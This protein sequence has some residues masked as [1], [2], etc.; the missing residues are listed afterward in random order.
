VSPGLSV[1]VPH[2]HDL[3]SLDRCLDCLSRQTY[4]A[5]QF[6]IIVADN[7][8]PEGL[9]EVARLVG[10]R[11][12]L[13]RVTEPGA[14]PARN[15]GVAL[16]RGAILAF[17]DCDCQPE[18]EWLAAG[19]RALGSC[20]I[21][22]G[23]MA[24][25]V[26]DPAHM[27]P[28]EAFERVFAFDNRSYVMRKGFTVTANLFCPRAIF[29]RVGGFL[30]ARVSEDIEWCHR[31]RGAGFRL[32]YAPEAV[33]GHPARRSWPDLLKK[34]RRINAELF[35]LAISRRGGRAWWLLRS[36]ALPLSAV[37]HT[38]K[39]L[40][41]QGLDTLGQRLAAVGVLYRLRFWRLADALR[42]FAAGSW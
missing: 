8:S 21:V 28:E 34:T 33:V 22:G 1:I 13:T 4:P 6:E 16:A 37:A 19:V 36:L 26:S 11:A 14:G 30:S 23:A 41:G 7:N 10:G 35:G 42:L 24:V 29:D 3:A 40:A 32:G 12:R 27:T 15:G 9:D 5:D 20:D 18:P 2:F 31:A 25:L 38:P 17:T 39:A